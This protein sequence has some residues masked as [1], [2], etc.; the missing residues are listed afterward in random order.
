[1]RVRWK[2]VFKGAAGAKDEVPDL[3]VGS[4]GWSALIDVSVVHSSAPSAGGRVDGAVAERAAGKG[5]KYDRAVLMS[6]A[7]VKVPFVVESHGAV[8]EGAEVF[9]AE[10]ASRCT[11]YTFED[12]TD[13]YHRFKDMVAIAVQRGHGLLVQ[14][15]CQFIGV[16]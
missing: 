14:R 2:P 11:D 10:L 3:E 13:V 15:V 7:S 8:G 6:G 1:M 12:Y 4:A 5:A 16:R 9:I